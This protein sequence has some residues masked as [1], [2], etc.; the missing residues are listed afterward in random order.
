MESI[1]DYGLIQPLDS[2]LFNKFRVMVNRLPS[3]V[4]IS[5]ALVLMG[6]ALFPI[7]RFALGI[8]AQIQIQFL[9]VVMMLIGGVMCG[10]T[11][12][13]LMVRRQPDLQWGGQRQHAEDE[14]EGTLSLVGLHAT[15][16]LVFTGIPLANFLACYALWLKT[17]QISEL[18]DKHGREAVCQQISFYLYTMLCLFMALLVIGVF[19]LLFLLCLHFIFCLIACYQ[20]KSG[21]LFRYPANIAII[22]RKLENN[23]ASNDQ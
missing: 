1:T 23:T 15:G 4:F 3:W 2:C 10:L 22:D 5:L 11:G 14:D 13:I 16:L 17:R 19:A 8:D 21:S 7:L 9:T 20:A 12:M 6:L 18:H